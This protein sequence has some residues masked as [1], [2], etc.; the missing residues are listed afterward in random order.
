MSKPVVAF[1]VAELFLTPSSLLLE[2][3]LLGTKSFRD[4]GLPTSASSAPGAESDPFPCNLAT[5]G[6]FG[7]GP[8]PLAFWWATVESFYRFW[9][10]NTE[11][12]YSSTSTMGF[13]IMIL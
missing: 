13:T 6:F 1:M 8:F 5:E 12:L 10:P 3:A 11:L 9:Y 7:I 2:P 4:A